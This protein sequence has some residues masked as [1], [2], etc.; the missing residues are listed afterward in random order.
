[1][2]KLRKITHTP[3][4]EFKTCPL[5]DIKKTALMVSTS[6]HP[7]LDVMVFANATV[8]NTTGNGR[9]TSS[10]VHQSLTE[11]TALADVPA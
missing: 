3:L 7:A 11:S 10:A 8:S 4:G 9:S 5:F 1:M 6:N 2:R